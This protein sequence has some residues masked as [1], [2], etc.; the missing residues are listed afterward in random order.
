MNII[1][2]QLAETIFKTCRLN[3]VKFSAAVLNLTMYR[4]ANLIDANIEHSSNFFNQ[5][6]ASSSQF[7]SVAEFRK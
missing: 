2:F 6:H 4:P 5:T 3:D 1:L 7:V